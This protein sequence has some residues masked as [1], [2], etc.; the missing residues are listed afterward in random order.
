[1]RPRSHARA[2]ARESTRGSE[3]KPTPWMAFDRDL[4]VCLHHHRHHHHR[5]RCHP[6]VT[7]TTSFLRPTYPNPTPALLLCRGFSL[8][9][10]VPPNSFLLT[11][12]SSA[13]S[14][15]AL[16]SG[17]PKLLSSHGRSDRR[18][19]APFVPSSRI[20]TANDEPLLFTDRR[21]AGE[22]TAKEFAKAIL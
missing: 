8:F 2:R 6:C 13:F 20:T 21:V 10:L 12:L 1:M 16:S 18:V 3:K 17:D 9:V 15:A 5:A 22:S 4:D 7:S 14:V 19:H 11:S